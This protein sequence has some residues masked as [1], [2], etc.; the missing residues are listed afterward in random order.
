MPTRDGMHA[1]LRR[2]PKVPK[3][4]TEYWD[5]RLFERRERDNT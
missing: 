3:E 5:R 1:P 4:L 2:R